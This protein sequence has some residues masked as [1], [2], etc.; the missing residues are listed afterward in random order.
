MTD[1]VAHA[2]A[3]DARAARNGTLAYVLSDGESAALQVAVTTT[4][5]LSLV[6]CAAVVFHAARII[7]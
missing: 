4:A 6:G 1:A 3:A 7:R 2:E 5:A